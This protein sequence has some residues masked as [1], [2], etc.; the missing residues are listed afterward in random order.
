M[1]LNTVRMLA[2]LSFM[3][4]LQS[5][6]MLGYGSLVVCSSQARHF[7][8]CSCNGMG[9]LQ[10]VELTLCMLN[11]FQPLQLSLHSQCLL[12]GGNMR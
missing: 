8:L 3:H 12:K 9:L 1:R 11:A 4:L 2:Y 7:L 6:L 5:V 10:H